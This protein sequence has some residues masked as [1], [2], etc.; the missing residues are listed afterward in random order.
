VDGKVFHESL[1]ISG[2]DGTL[3][4]RLKEVEGK[5]RAKTGTIGGVRALSGY[6]ET[7]GRTLVFSILLNDIENGQEAGAIGKMDA[8]V[9][10][11]AK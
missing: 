4:N 6:I 9:V 10:E 5:V 8:A 2:I 1:P 11:M 3:K 7:E